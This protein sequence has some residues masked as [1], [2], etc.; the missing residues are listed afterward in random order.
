[1]SKDIG[2]IN[3]KESLWMR[4]TIQIQVVMQTKITVLLNNVAIDMENWP[5]LKINYMEK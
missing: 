5:G 3:L 2:I 4:R 1:M